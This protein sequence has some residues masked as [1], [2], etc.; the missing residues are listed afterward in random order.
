MKIVKRINKGEMLPPFY[1]VA[2]Q[3]WY[4][5][6]AVCL[7]VPL[8]LIAAIGRSIWIFMRHGHR[9]VPMSPRDAYYQGKNDALRGNNCRED[10]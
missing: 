6:V 3:D 8:N 5:D 2:W 1:G 4:G 7:P 9:H 10:V